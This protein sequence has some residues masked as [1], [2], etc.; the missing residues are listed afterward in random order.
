MANVEP[1]T[2]INSDKIQLRL[3]ALQGLC[4][5][6]FDFLDQLYDTYY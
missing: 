4:Q 6:P 2:G 5:T 3:V 1:T